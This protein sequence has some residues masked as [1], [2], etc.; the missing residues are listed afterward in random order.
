MKKIWIICL[1]VT[2]LGIKAASAQTLLDRI[3]RTLNNADRAAN[4]A[5]RTSQTGSKI[6]GIFGKK[7]KSADAP[8]EKGNQ[9]TI[10]ISGVTYA[11]LKTLN[12]AVSASKNVNSTKMKFASS[13]SSII[14]D[15]N[16]DTEALLKTLQKSSPSVFAEKNIDGVEDGKI[17]IKLKK[18]G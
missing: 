3:D 11:S 16:G 5:D 10:K 15:H 2:L 4:A 13:G 1:A 18:Q 17:E 7:K 12:D 14:V 6:G 9:T 8:A